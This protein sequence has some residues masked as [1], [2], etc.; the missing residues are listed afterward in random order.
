MLSDTNDTTPPAAGPETPAQ[1]TQPSEESATQ[2]T[3]VA[4][5]PV[6][7]AF[8]PAQLAQPAVA[9]PAGNNPRTAG[10][11]NRGWR[12]GVAAAVIVV[13][14]GAFF[15]IGWFTSTRGDHGRD[16]IAQV[17]S[18]RMK[19]LPQRGFQQRGAGQQAPGQWQG[20][21]YPNRQYNG[22]PNQQTPSTQQA[23]SNQQTPSTQ[24]AP[25][26]Q[27]GYLGI[28]VETVTP[29]L[30]QQYG[31]SSAT[32]VLVASIDNT[33]PASQAGIQR[34]DVITSID[35][36]PVTTQEEVVNLVETKTA[37]ES[38]SVVVERSGQSLTFQVTLAA[39]PATIS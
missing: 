38:I 36:T 5:Q 25:S 32:G 28:G 18:Q 15:T 12:Y 29:A 3:E 35:G 17:M 4:P 31:L 27:Q 14:A 21:N 20:P 16:T 1:A 6:Q 22:Q 24:Q 9:P 7:P 33:G 11:F 34:G 2:P 37:G 10:W 30:Q 39:R 23:P 13:V 19:N 8:V 26:S